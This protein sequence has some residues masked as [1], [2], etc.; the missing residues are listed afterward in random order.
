MPRESPF[1]P[2]VLLRAPSS[3][4]Y[5]QGMM[6]SKRGRVLALCSA[7]CFCLSSQAQGALPRLSTSG[8]NIV[9][10]SGKT[11]VLRGENL[12]GAFEI[13]P[14]MS[15]LNLSSPTA[16]L[17]Q[18]PDESTLWKVLTKRFGASQTQQLQHTWRTSWISP[19]DISNLASMGANVVRIPF[20]YQMLQDDSNPGQL[21]PEGVALLNALL[22]ACAQNGVYAI[23]DMH[24][25]PG[26]QSSNFT[27]GQSG[28]NQLF[29]SSAYQQQTI[30]L[31]GLI[32]AYYQSRPEVAGY[33]LI[34][35]PT[36]ATP[37]QLIDLHNRIYQAIRAVD[38]QHIIFME[39]GY[40]GFTVFPDPKKMGWTQICYSMHIY[41]L[42]ALTSNP[43]QQDI[44][45]T[46]PQYR[47]QQQAINTPLYIGEFNTEG[48]LLSR[49]TAL[50]ALPGYVSAFNTYGWSWT[51][52]TYK[53]FDANS[54]TNKIWGLY[55]NNSP[56]NE[57]D[58]YNDSFQVLQQKFA[59]YAAAN[60]QLQTDLQSSLGL[61]VVS[62]A[63]TNTTPPVITSIDSASAYG[64]YSYFASGSWLE[65][66][67]TNLVDPSDPRLTAAV[68][69]GQW[70]L[71][72]FNGVNAPTVLD[73]ISVSINGK[74]A[75]VWYLSTTQV[76]A[77]AP[78]DSATGNVAI[79]ITNCK[80]TSS[81]VMFARRTLAPGLLAP[82]NY[83]AG[84][85]QY[86][87]ATFASDGAYVLN[88]TTGA[89]LGLTSRPAKPGDVIIAY[90]IGFGDVTP[91]I[92]PGVIVQQ[93]NSLIS[94]VTFS[95][96]SA[97]ATLQYSGLAG[98]FV[99]LY[100][101]YITVPPG[102]A[103]GDYLINV[104]QSGTPVPQSMYLTVHN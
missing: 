49:S 23:L 29:T 9:D 82:P 57:A 44:T 68:N 92:L 54:G 13:E 76:N 46:F 11:V 12:G 73:G 25:A 31:W 2:P 19:A 64:A 104:T 41:H 83:S 99:G 10:S 60:V 43:F 35:E 30:Q 101:F 100:E 27:T 70:T 51:P 38:S 22:D 50:T 75:Y 48:T 28:L 91:S 18:I 103:N 65:I 21:I 95:F 15:A 98:G 102:L 17:P 42:T 37:A 24:G 40:M 58:P 94:P 78:E 32:A 87:V 61:A 86:M 47:Q 89:G 16:G 59:N 81:P 96:G 84:G 93:S 34:N 14:W 6:L 8:M 62:G 66:K 3:S 7:A 5:N 33:D 67:G 20:F 45:T 85:T 88:T 72:D 4:H 79:T 53:L 90:G 39:D 77:Q 56:W 52:W 71:K 69:P 63:C 80:A 36:S 26:G 74:P 1:D 55:T 97:N